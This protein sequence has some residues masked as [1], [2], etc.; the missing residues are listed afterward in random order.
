MWGSFLNVKVLGYPMFFRE[1]QKIGWLSLAITSITI[2]PVLSFQNNI[3][4]SLGIAGTILG[5]LALGF[6]LYLL[7]R[8]VNRYMIQIF[9]PKVEDS[10]KELLN[11][12]IDNKK[13]DI[14]SWIEGDLRKEA[15]YKECKRKGYLERIDD[16]V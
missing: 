2:A 4:Q 7:F 1:K 6:I 3:K 13:I 15:A 10:K 14:Q 12:L 8:L 5:G 16:V 9:D 11:Y